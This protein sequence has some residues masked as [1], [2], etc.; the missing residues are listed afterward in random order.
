MAT[1]RRKVIENAVRRRDQG[2]P[3]N[4]VPMSSPKSPLLGEM[5]PAVAG[6]L[7]SAQPLS[8]FRGQGGQLSRADR[9]GLVD[10]ALILMEQNFVHRPLKEAM[11]AVRPVQRLRLLR[12][13][14]E[15]GEERDL[16][17]AW[18]FHQ[19]MLEIFASV[20]D[21]HTNYIL[22]PTF[23][24]MVAF[25]PFLIESF[26]E[27][28]QRRYL[29][30]HLVQGFDK[31]PF[32]RGVE[33]LSW[34][35]IPI[36]RAVALNAQRFAGSNPEARRARGIERLTVRPLLLSLPPDEDWVIVGYRTTDGQGHELRVDWHVAQPGDRDVQDLLAPTAATANSVA[37]E[38]AMGIDI[39]AEMA[40]RAKKILF[41]PPTTEAESA[42]AKS[43]ANEAADEVTSRRPEMSARV[44]ETSHG[45]FGYV[46]IWTFAPADRNE[47]FEKFLSGFVGE[48]ARL[49]EALPQ[50]GLVVDVRSNGGGIIYAGEMLLQL[51]TPHHIEPERL[52][53]INTPLNMELCRL[54]GP[55]SGIDLS[56]WVP[57]MSESV[58]TGAIYSRAFP[59]TTED[60]ANSI[61]QRYY[62]P[63][64]LVTD[65]RCYS[66]TDI[67]AAGF[68]DHE[69]GAVLGVDMNT[70]AGGANVWTHE[71]LRQLMQASPSS[72]YAQLPGGAQMRVAIRQTVRV[73]KRAGTL[74]RA[75]N[76]GGRFG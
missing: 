72:P 70:G 13:R 67:F 64:V 57:S 35:G 34:N 54:N 26:V 53:F 7:G 62:G 12:Q 37:I 10:Q 74:N 5:D 4:V 23:S 3:E 66:T 49:I 58:Q 48:F 52:Q 11:H 19:E 56:P 63:V 1:A 47:P 31:P 16:S 6:N 44:V 42:L 27:A 59:I 29:V 18:Q 2:S 55:R 20:R 43:G 73:G 40:G 9:L 69:I 60:M 21:L 68:Q 46:R 30:S 38:T 45:R 76:P 36:D 50:E 71:L 15:I 32:A 51:L 33:V 22:P 14:I 65:A 24:G 28:G 39:D 8:A 41:A 75:G 61:G 17:E 25:L